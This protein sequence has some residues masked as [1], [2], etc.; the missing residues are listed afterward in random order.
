M[1]EKHQRKGSGKR[2]QAAWGDKSEFEQ[3]KEKG[4]FFFLG[5]KDK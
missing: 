3:G 5:K 1:R 2:G 4:E